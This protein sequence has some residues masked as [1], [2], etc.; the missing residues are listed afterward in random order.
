MQRLSVQ[1]LSLSAVALALAGCSA[2]A[3]AV[4][5]ARQYVVTNSS[6]CAS[7]TGLNDDDCGAMIEKAIKVHTEKS[8]RYTRLPLCEKTEGVDQCERLEDKVWIPKPQGILITVSKSSREAKM[9]FASRN[10]SATFRTADN[11][12]LDPEKIAAKIEYSEA[13]FKRAEAMKRKR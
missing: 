12:V 4:T 7:M 6:E 5:N 3:P 13:A 9:L 1:K 2:A 10:K 8:T 11:T